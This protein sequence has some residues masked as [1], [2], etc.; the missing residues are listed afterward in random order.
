MSEEEWLEADAE[1][2]RMAGALAGIGNALIDLDDAFE[3]ELQTCQALGELTLPIWQSHPKALNG[4]VTKLITHA[5]PGGRALAVIGASFMPGKL[6]EVLRDARFTLLTV[7][8]KIALP[9]WALRATVRPE[10]SRFVLTRE[11]E[12]Q[13]PGL[14]CLFERDGEEF[15]WF[16]GFDHEDCGIPVNFQPVPTELSAEIEHKVLNGAYDGNLH[17]VEPLTEPEG[18]WLLESGLTALETHGF[19]VAKEYEEAANDGIGTVLRN[20]IA[21]TSL[22]RWHMHDDA[23]RLERP[24]P[25]HGKHFP[26]ERWRTDPGS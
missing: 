10:R 11:A 15:G 23:P 22:L 6:G 25:K 26:F 2:D 18:R 12:A 8:R 21:Y 14:F 16:I 5:D 9:A 24:L 19:K 17:S 7:G 20:R 13:A 3:R 4:F 1:M